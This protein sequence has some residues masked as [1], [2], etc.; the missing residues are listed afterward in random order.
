M[1]ILYHLK[2]ERERRKDQEKGVH[3]ETLQL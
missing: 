3:E 2:Y 1:F